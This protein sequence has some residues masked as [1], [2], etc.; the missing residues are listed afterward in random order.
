MRHRFSSQRPQVVMAVCMTNWTAVASVPLLA[1]G[2]ALA[3]ACL[4]P[5]AA[6]GQV[7][8]AQSDDGQ[9]PAQHD[10]NVLPERFEDRLLFPVEEQAV[11]MARRGLELPH[12]DADLSR[13][14]LAG[15]QPM[16]R[17][18]LVFRPLSA[19]RGVVAD[20]VSRRF[21]DP[22]TIR[23]SKFRYPWEDRHLDAL[24]WTTPPEEGQAPE[25]RLEVILKDGEGVALARHE[26]A[27]LSPHGLFFSVGFPEALRGGTGTLE[28]VW[29]EGDVE[30]GR[31]EAAFHV[32]RQNDAPRSG[33]VPLR[34]LNQPGA[35]I[36]NAPMTVGVPFPHGVLDDQ[37][38]VRLVNDV[39]MQMG[40]QTRVA[41]RWSRFG[42]V[43][44][45]LCDFTVDLDGQPRKV[46]LEYG[47]DVRRS[48]AAAL[49]A[50]ELVT[51]FPA[52]DAGRV[53]VD[54][55]G[56]SFDAAGDGD[57][58]PVLAPQ[59]LLG[60]FV[61]HEDGR[62]YCM[63]ADAEYAFEEL[64]SQ[65]AV[66]RRTGWYADKGT[67][68][69]FCNFVTRF[70]FHRDSPVVRIFHTWIFTGDGNRDRIA[71]MGWRFDAAHP[72]QGGGFL[73]AFEDGAWISAPSL[74][75]FD[76]QTFLLP[77]TGSEQEGRT[78]GVL[79]ALVGDSRVTF[80][81]KDFWQNF[82]SELE[83]G[84]QGFTFYN[85]PKRNPPARFQRPVA[86]EDAFRHRF[87]HEGQVL[88]FRLPD[89]YAMGEIWQEASSREGHWS[90]GRPETANAQ[91]IARTEELFLYFADDSL[92]ADDAAKVIRGLNDE[93]LRAVVDPVWMTSSGVFSIGGVDL[94]PHDSENFPEEER[95]YQLRVEAPARWVERLGVYG[96]WVYG[97]YP[98]WSM[99]LPARSVSTY[100]TYRKNHGDSPGEYPYRWIPFIRSG[101]PR[102]LK[103]AES[104][105]RQMADAS[106]CHYATSDV[107]QTVGPYHFRRQGWWDR[108]L[109]PWAGRL[110]PHLR[111]YTIDTDYLWDAYYVTGYLRTRDVSLLFG[112]L[113]KNS[114]ETTSG[115]RG[116]NQWLKSYLDMYKATFDPWFLNAAHEVA[117]LHVHNY[118][119]EKELDPLMY[120]HPRDIVG[121]EH[122]RWADQ[123]FHAFT[124]CD[125]F[126]VVARN[127]AAGYANPNMVVSRAGTGTAGGAAAGL[128]AHA[129]R[130][131]GDPFYLGRLAATLDRLRCTS[132]E[133]DVPWMRGPKV[134]GHGWHAGGPAAGED[135]G[136]PMAM[137]VLS[138]LESI[139]DPIHDL[140]WLQSGWP[141][142]PEAVIYVRDDGHPGKFDLHFYVRGGAYPQVPFVYSIHGPGGF[143]LDGESQTPETIEVSGG[144][145]IYR[146]EV[147][148][149]RR[150][151]SDIRRLYLPLAGHE[152]PEVIGF[153]AS[154]AGTSVRAP[155]L[156]YWFHVPEGTEE[157]WIDFT[158]RPQAREYAKRVSVWNPDG[159]RAW[160]HSYSLQDDPPTPSRATLSVPEG[161]D[162]RLW[163]ATGGD[164]VIDPNIPP[165]FSVSQAK[166]FNP[167]K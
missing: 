127:S 90:E 60:A 11:A 100:R 56:L 125:W 104:G 48:E 54:E 67:G 143:D 89:E 102:L 40:L 120:D 151:S 41:A 93:T 53:R 29:R 160:D 155:A 148:G 149:D 65:K 70:V 12:S 57:F 131:T 7:V 132:Y 1:W 121:F 136:V 6:G 59:A 111:S 68:D 37:R 84:D 134:A 5:G 80:G 145:G 150:S 153:R 23:L 18:Q 32:H 83:I 158:D 30:L 117:A 45:L 163:R 8:R 167:E 50:G 154:E 86:R 58:R 141:G 119:R 105:A 38:N 126:G 52:L 135:L 3:V 14:A 34:I 109:L 91:G 35:T 147:N 146:V 69:R 128:S 88:D 47:P 101:N 78:P 64:G 33:R 142:S 74:V 122:W 162:G 61:S 13:G 9:Q 140:V 66:V 103:L 138:K 63:P 39:G 87:V 81:A 115:G 73:N 26:L 15:V 137:S 42:P 107:D 99:N 164:F 108:S 157:F 159:Q 130:H 129:W 114:H 95:A 97:D 165:Y 20:T 124:G 16:P 43:K 28:V 152:M 156:G 51:G 106:F 133:G 112:E 31:A 71:S 144:E 161:M 96:M 22:V 72:V 166:W 27:E 76:Y 110:G 36:R 75:Q 116:S 139:P 77:E 92:S 4:L 118:W 94:H 55:Q 82:P 44:W 98:T 49:G 79:S 123:A 46:Y 85:W 62:T 10:L 24:V 21:D 113:T 2:V 19:T 25:G 17:R